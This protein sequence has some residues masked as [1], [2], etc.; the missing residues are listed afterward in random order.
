MK[1]S[2]AQRVGI[3]LTP[4]VGVGVFLSLPE[5][6]ADMPD[7]VLPV[8][9]VAVPAV[10]FWT[11]AILTVGLP[12]RHRLSGWPLLVWFVASMLWQMQP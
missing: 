10:T 5:L 12:T 8:A 6:T 1:P 7:L 2:P 9:R 11:V 3:T 4:V